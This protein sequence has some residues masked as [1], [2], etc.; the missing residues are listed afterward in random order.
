MQ[1]RATPPTADTEDEIS[2]IDLIGVLWRRRWTISVFAGLGALLGLGGSLASLRYVSEGLFVTDI[3]IE[4]Y[5]RYENAV[6]SGPRLA[7]F[8]RRNGAESAEASAQLLELA[9]D[10]SA[11]GK[12]L[13]LESSF[14]DRDA[15]TYGGQTGKENKLFFRLKH[16]SQ[17]PAGSAPLVLL[18]E[19][20][21]D[22]IIRVDME[23]VM[24]RQCNGERI[25][26]Q[27]L[28]NAQIQNEFDIRQEEER[29]A[30]LRTLAARHAD[31]MGR[32]NRQIVAVE[33]DT[34]RFLPLSAQL[35]AAEIRIADMRLADASRERE[36][37]A[38]ALRRD[39][40]CKAQAALQARPSG[41]A[42]LIEL[43]NVQKTAFEGKDRRAGV[44]EQTWNELKL[45][46]RNWTNTYL[47]LTR[48]AVPPDGA[49]VRERK[50]GMITG[51]GLGAMLGGGA[52]IF[53]ALML[54]WW[55]GNR[56]EVESK[57]G[58]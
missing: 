41:R 22:A 4:S 38:T 56:N 3:P 19:F 43:G 31:A 16:E 42:F 27:T 58:R 35:A 40:Y 23:E 44:V 5:R 9:E 57:Q 54:G 11:L 15:R 13:Q 20:V 34:E 46:R 33:K 2:L 24:P 18:G 45:Q 12:A 28:Q 50:L 10:A 8:V 17:E 49:E 55:R 32:D 39:Y 30:T 26:E 1:N 14:T 48:F 21:R 25:R 37:E 53:W 51:V 52:G 36:R 7:Q 47:D 29:A 6:L